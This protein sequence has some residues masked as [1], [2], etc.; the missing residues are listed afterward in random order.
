MQ[1]NK[2]HAK[3]CANCRRSFGGYGCK[4]MKRPCKLGVWREEIAKLIGASVCKKKRG[5]GGESKIY[6]QGEIDLC[7]VQ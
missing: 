6:K 4:I 3:Q 7:S 2:T 1:A 5:G